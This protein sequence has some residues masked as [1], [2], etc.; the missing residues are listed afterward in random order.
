MRDCLAVGAGCDPASEP[1]GEAAVREP[2]FSRNS[3]GAVL[4]EYSRHAMRRQSD[5]AGSG[6]SHSFV[7]AHHGHGFRPE[8]PLRAEKTWFQGFGSADEM[9]GQS[10]FQSG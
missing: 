10:G 9:D 2:R 1:I 6:A 7:L 4:D 5:A 3:A 8:P